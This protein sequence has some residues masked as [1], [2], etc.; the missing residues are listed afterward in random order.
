MT[1]ISAPLKVSRSAY[2]VDGEPMPPLESF[3]T[4]EYDSKQAALEAAYQ[5]MY[6][7]TRLPHMK[8]PYI[9]EP[10]GSNPRRFRTGVK[11]AL[12]NR[13]DRDRARRGRPR[14][15]R[16]AEKLASS[17]AATLGEKTRGKNQLG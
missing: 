4:E 3:H 12:N 15:A 16:G 11:S 17:W 14:R 10:N 8:V 6:G 9:V 13:R 7:L 2:R 5:M 1:V